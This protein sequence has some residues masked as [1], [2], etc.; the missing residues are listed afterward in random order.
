MIGADVS[1]EVRNVLSVIGEYA[2]LLDDLVGL[3]DKGRPLDHAKL[4]NL[5]T[6][7]AKQVRRGTETMERFSRFA[8]AADEPLASFDLVALVENM[9]ALVQRRAALAGCR[10]QAEFSPPAIPVRGDPFALQHLVFSAIQA[11][12]ESLEKEEPI[13]VKVARRGPEAVLCVSGPAAGGEP[14]GRISEQLSAAVDKCRASLE[15]SLAD[16]VLSLVFTIPIQ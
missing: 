14:S 1:H 5:S 6:N 9:V 10:V 7:I 13:R 3:A 11:M 2:G 8:H 16:G 15:T 4:R 12:L